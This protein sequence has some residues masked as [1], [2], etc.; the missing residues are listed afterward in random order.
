MNTCG[1]RTN[2]ASNREGFPLSGS[3]LCNLNYTA[4]NVL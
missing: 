4:V 2:T 3:P 1:K